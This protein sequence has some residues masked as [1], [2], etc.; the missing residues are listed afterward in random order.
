MVQP[1]YSPEEA[2]QRVKLM[3]GYDTNKTLTE[4][5]SKTGAV[6]NEQAQQCSNPTT[7]DVIKKAA[8]SAGHDAYALDS[9]LG[10]FAWNTE[11]KA[12]NIYQQI[13]SISGKNYMDAITSKCTPAVD[14]FNK[15]FRQ[16]TNGWIQGGQDFVAYLTKIKDESD[17]KDKVEI[18]RNLD[19]AIAEY[20]K[21][22]TGGGG[23]TGVGGGKTVGG[24]YKPCQEGKYVRG[25]QSTR[26]SQVQAC[27]NAKIF[28]D[29]DSTQPIGTDGKFGPKTQALLQSKFPKFVNGFTDEDVKTI[30]AN[31]PN[32]NNKT[33]Y[34][35]YTTTETEDTTPNATVTK[36]ANVTNTVKKDE[37]EQ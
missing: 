10:L 13:K 24:G 17:Y 12:A 1:K 7:E 3:M 19:A 28:M 32:P 30:C 21:S 37:A 4:N 26:I 27:L 9:T 16:E 20:N 23:K 25:C 33:G 6:L 22:S 14:L 15:Y 5:I 34:E 31:I 36:T 8:E 18:Q 11:Q 2:L 29:K 35:D